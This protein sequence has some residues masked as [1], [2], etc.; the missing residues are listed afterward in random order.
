MAL[1]NPFKKAA[2]KA[3]S[4]VTKKVVDQAKEKVVDAV[5]EVKEEVMN[6]GNDILPYF[7][8]GGVILIGIALVRRQPPIT[9]KVVVKQK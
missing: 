6:A 5:K 3:T 7:V 2:S 4:K 9:V 8:V 1:P